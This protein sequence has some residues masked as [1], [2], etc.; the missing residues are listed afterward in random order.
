MRVDGE[1]LWN[2]RSRERKAF[3]NHLKDLVGS[4]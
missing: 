3:L 4:K 2:K 1:E